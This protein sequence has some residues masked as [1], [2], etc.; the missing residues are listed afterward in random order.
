MDNLSLDKQKLKFQSRIEQL[1]EELELA[2]E[3]LELLGGKEQTNVTP[4]IA[5]TLHKRGYLFKW[6]DRSIGWSGSKWG[7]R[8]V[9]LEN[10]R[11]S[12]YGTHNE[13]AAR[14]G[15]MLRGLA[16]RDDGWKRN[17]RHTSRNGQDPPLDEPGAYFFVFSIYERQ[18]DTGSD[19]VNNTEIVPLLR[20]ST[21]SSAEKTQWIQLISRSCAYCETDVFL[22]DEAARIAEMAKRQEE[23]KNMA[24]IFPGSRDEILKQNET[25]PLLYFAPAVQPSLTNK[26]LPSVSSH[27]K[28]MDHAQSSTKIRRST[29]FQTK[30]ANADL[31]KVEARSKR[32]YPASK[33]MHREAASSLLSPDAKTQNFRGFLNLGI[34]VLLVSNT[35]LLLD[36]IRSHGFVLPLALPSLSDVSHDPWN[37]V[38]FITAAL[39]QLGFVTLAFFIEWMLSKGK[40]D[41]YLGMV[42]HYM[43]AH[44]ALVMPAIVVWTMIDKPVTGFI[45]LFHAVMTWMKLI[46]YLQANEDYRATRG[47]HD[48]PAHVFRRMVE[49]LDLHEAHLTYPDNVTLQNMLYFWCAPTLTYQIAFPKF[50]RVRWW[51]VL[52]ILSRM[53]AVV[54]VGS[55]LVAQVVNP[56]LKGLLQDLEAAQGQYTGRIFFQYW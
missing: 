46:S 55:F 41:E 28:R 21:P 30:S 45:L 43:N 37:S 40:L 17:R 16:V 13:N 11:L 56:T 1:K 51:K 52:T 31:D 19:S 24:M 35:R 2:R 49:D 38:P 22:E 53:I 23:Q 5:P 50:P 47:Q 26:R 29:S 25:L 14:Y 36:S 6:S 39:F 20:F 48:D 32:S 18:D 12:Y 34:L 10:G 8:Y 15:V 27:A 9:V 4:S 33:P 3:E 42:L 7:L 54:M 44:T